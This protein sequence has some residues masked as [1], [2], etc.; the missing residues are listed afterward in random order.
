MSERT[1]ILEQLDLLEP[2]DLWGDIERRQPGP[3]AEPIIPNSRRLMVIAVAFAIAAGAIALPI[4]ALM[5]GSGGGIG[6]T[7]QPQTTNVPAAIGGSFVIQAS[8]G[9]DQ[10]THLYIVQD[11][12]EPRRLSLD[13]GAPS[14]SPDGTAFVATRIVS[15][16]ETELVAVDVGTGKEH[17]VTR[18]DHP[19]ES[20]WSPSG[21]W[22][23]FVTQD[24]AIYRIHPDGTGLDRVTDPSSVCLDGPP[25][26]S[27]DSTSIVFGRTCDSGG[28]QGMYVAQADGNDL[29]RI[30]EEP[31]IGRP[32]WS[33]D[34]GTIAFTIWD[35]DDRPAIYL[36]H[37]DGSEMRLLATDA[38]SPSW[39]VRGD[40][41]AV[42]RSGNLEILDVAS[43]ATV[44]MVAT[45][46]LIVSSVDWSTASA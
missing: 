42:V 35:R 10:P 30:S 26:W 22:I 13:G 38:G 28:D 7:P 15:E 5:G 44:A 23:A 31:G 43:S 46:G 17:V 36:I 24:G 8:E 25:G 19:Q 20:T 11:G 6:T 16:S 34:R 3:E 14:L 29:T 4:V 2:T 33:P 40:E 18:F 39:S 32:S 21:E 41:M 45:P 12:G 27:P 1:K 9:A 37:R